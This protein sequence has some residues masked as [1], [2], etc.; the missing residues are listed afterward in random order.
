MRVFISAGESGGE[1]WSSRPKTEQSGTRPVPPFSC[2]C[3]LWP[4]RDLR[5]PERDD[6][7]RNP[8]SSVDSTAPQKFRLR[9]KIKFPRELKYFGVATLSLVAG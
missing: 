3:E 5:L 8:T 7:L 9:Q 6:L 1:R 4:P 2:S